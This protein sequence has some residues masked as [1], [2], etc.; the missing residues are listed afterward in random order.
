MYAHYEGYVYIWSVTSL[1]I[2]IYF[3]LFIY[4]FIIIIQDDVTEIWLETSAGDHNGPSWD[5]WRRA[6]IEL[7]DTRKNCPPTWRNNKQKYLIRKYL[8]LSIYFSIPCLFQIAVPIYFFAEYNYYT[9][10]S[11]LYGEHP[12]GC[13][14]CTY[15]MMISSKGVS[16]APL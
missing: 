9:I 10:H 14:G 11:G 7:G 8:E 5:Q 1:Y 6:Y 12:E 16:K 2:Y 4:F 13:L 3:Y 15:W